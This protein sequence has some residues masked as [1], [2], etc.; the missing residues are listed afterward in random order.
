MGGRGGYKRSR[1]AEAHVAIVTTIKPTVSLTAQVTDTFDP[2]WTI[3]SGCTR[4]VP[5]HLEWMT[6]RRK[7]N[8]VMEQSWLEA[9]ARFQS[10]LLGRSRSKP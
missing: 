7:G 6:K 3:D 5:H 4:H 10:K 1:R 9:S 2:V 8:G